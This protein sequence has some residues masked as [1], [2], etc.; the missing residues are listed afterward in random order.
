[1]LSRFLKILWR[2]LYTARSRT[3]KQTQKI[4]HSAGKWVPLLHTRGLQQRLQRLIDSC[5]RAGRRIG[6]LLHHLWPL[7]P[8]VKTCKKLNYQIQQNAFFLEFQKRVWLKLSG[9]H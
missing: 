8:V 4:N 1:M 5:R 3:T 7:I 6:L 9:Y 2:Y